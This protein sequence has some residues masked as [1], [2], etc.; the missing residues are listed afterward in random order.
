MDVVRKGSIEISI[1]GNLW[2]TVRKDIGDRL[3]Q[4]VSTMNHWVKG[5]SKIESI[6]GRLETSTN[7]R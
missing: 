4:E 6:R 7:H 1:K 5:A 3:E 2:E